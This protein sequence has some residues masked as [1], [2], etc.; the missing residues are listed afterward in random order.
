MPIKSLFA[1][2]VGLLTLLLLAASPLYAD[3]FLQSAPGPGPIRIQKE[4]KKF[5]LVNEKGKQVLPARYDSLQYTPHNDYFIAYMR[6]SD[7]VQKA[8][9]IN[10]KGK[11]LIPIRYKAIRPVSHNRYAVIDSNKKEALFDETGV[12]RTGFEFD[13]ITA[14][15]GKLARFYQQGKAGI[16]DVEGRVRLKAQYQD[17]IIRSN[18]AV[19]AVPV[20]KW[21]ITDG[22]NKLLHTLSYDSIRPL[23]EDR[24][25]ATTRFYDSVGRP[26]TMTALTDATGSILM[27]YRPMFINNFEDGVARVKEGAHFGLIDIKGNY[28]LPAEW[29]SL[30]VVQGIAVAGMRINAKWYWH[31]FNLKGKKQSRY[32]YEFIVPVNEGPMPAK[33]EGRWGYIDHTGAEVLLSR[34]D[35]TYA[36]EKEL[37]RVRFNGQEGVI[38]KEGLWQI[39]PIAEHITILSPTRFLARMKKGFQ[40]LNEKGDILYQTDD[41]L[42]PL[43]GG[44]AEINA[45]RQWGLIDINGKRLSF[46]LYDY[47]SDLQ[48]GQVFIASLEGKRGILSQDG[49]KF[50][51]AGPKTWER[52]YSMSEGFI[53]AQIGRQ[54]GFVDTNGLLRIANRYDTVTFFSD[55]M[56]AVAIRG[57][58]GYVDKIER[59]RVQP[60]Y[61][62]AQ[63]FIKGTAIVQL[64]SMQGVIDSKG[65]FVIPLE[66]NKITRLSNGR[67]LLKQGD[68]LGLAD[69]Q[70]NRIIAPKYNAVQDLQNGYLLVSR[71]GKKG[72]VTIDGVGTIPLVYDVL[73]YDPKNDL[74]L[75]TYQREGI[76]RI[77][78]PQP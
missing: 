46:P 43:V 1:P 22:N 42:K 45:N 12:A 53:G 18:E 67:F 16:L 40:L 58:W 29:D 19:D 59:L 30:A 2:F 70:G 73:I 17:I 52:L 55:G 4:G 74:Y 14:F 47:I 50:I 76:Q 78:L 24:W 41:V 71:G 33:R 38:N 63:P 34:Y 57:K 8:G 5:G 44:I 65:K 62:H 37:A 6:G 75:S 35:T 15:Q 56:A 60:M 77:T 7:K 54:Q 32:T 51:A 61:D 10:S 28:V 31:L 9:L 72:L 36:F 66:Y 11:E 27:P 39:R 20:R 48:E 49:R 68:L 26:T 23:G 3:V 69:A 13:E 25:A 64:G 21:T